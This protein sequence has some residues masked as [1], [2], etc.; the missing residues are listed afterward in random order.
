[1]SF[2]EAV[3][4]RDRL[5]Q[6]A[7]AAGHVLNAFP[8]GAM[9]L[10]PDHVRATPEWRAA[11]DRYKRAFAAL[12]N[13]NTVFTKA[14]AKE[15]RA[16]RAERRGGMTSKGHGDTAR[17]A[18]GGLEEIESGAVCAHCGRV[19]QKCVACTRHASHFE[20]VPGAQDTFLCARHAASFPRPHGNIS[21]MGCLPKRG[22]YV[23]RLGGWAN[24]TRDECRPHAF[25]WSTRD[26]CYVCGKCGAT[27]ERRSA[28]M[29]AGDV[30]KLDDGREWRVLAV[31]ATEYGATYVHLASV[32]RGVSQ[33][34]GHRPLQ[35][36]GWLRGSTLA[37]AP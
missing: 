15:L 3:A 30:L 4:A 22:R 6:E 1:M 31:G 28:S 21:P 27:R 14:F 25:E 12:Q 2:E 10:T 11:K 36:C 33:K 19:H 35:I 29:K 16:Q 37:S 8:R 26:R 20:Y 24:M 13:F 32:A 34:N 23:A 7:S 18:P 17:D 9:G 5:E